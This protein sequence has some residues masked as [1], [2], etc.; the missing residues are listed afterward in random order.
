MGTF[1]KHT[2]ITIATQCMN[3]LL[4]LASS[5]VIARILGPEGQGIYS[6]AFLLPTFLVIFM[7]LGI[8][9]ASVFYIGKKKYP[10]QSIA[11]INI[12]FSLAISSGAIIVGL[13]A[14]FL[15]GDHLFPGIKITYLLLGLIIVPFQVFLSLLINILLGLQNIKKYN[16]VYLLR[17]ASFLCFII[18]LLLWF[19]LGISAAIICLVLSVCFASVLAFCESVKEAEG[20]VFVFDK[21]MFKDFLNYGSKVFLNNVI[22]FLHLRL[23]V[24]LINLLLNP[25][26]VGYYAIAVGL[27][28]RIWLISQSAGTVLFPRV[29]AETDEKK[30]RDFTPIVC[31]NILLFTSIIAVLLFFM[32]RWLIIMFFSEQYSSSVL[33]FQILLI[34]TIAISGSRILANDLAGRGR[35]IENIYLSAFSVVINIIF[36]IILI[37]RIGIPGAA[38]ATTISYIITFAGRAIIYSKISGNRM[39]D[40]LFIKKSDCRLYLGILCEYPGFK[41]NNYGQCSVK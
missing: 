29:T 31:R 21:P 3:I 18:I 37:P 40:V 2:L 26:A 20:V 1:A 9:P 36:N 5:I 14:I 39:R 30:L 33:P 11:G 25:V 35:L 15:W 32:S 22:S 6:I 41:K 27:S 7:N 24:F 19:R 28:E 10:L 16:A 17:D 8:G 4:V 38:L 12:I 34:G 23:D 13:I